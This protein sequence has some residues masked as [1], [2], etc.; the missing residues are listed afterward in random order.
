MGFGSFSASDW[1]SY[2]GTIK[3]KAVDKIYTSTSTPKEFLPSEITVREAFDTTDNPETTPIILALDVTGSMGSVLESCAK[4]IG[5]L[6]LS[7]IDRKTVL[8]PQIA[9][10]AIGDVI[11]DSEPALQFTQFESDNR[12]AHQLTQLHFTRGGGGNDNESYS[13]AWLAGAYL[14]DCHAL[15]KRNKKGYLFTFGD[16]LP[17]QHLT[18]EHIRKIFPNAD[19]VPCSE[20]GIDSETA[21]RAAETKWHCFHIIIA[22]GSYAR[23]R[24][25]EV[26]E[27]WTNLMGQRAIV[28]DNVN[29]I[30]EVI[31]SIIEVNE[32]RDAKEVIESWD[33]SKAL[34]VKTAI[35]SLTSASK[36]EAGLVPL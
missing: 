24:P 34:S 30:S 23:A 2:S 31:T 18:F 27:H 8:G 5:E 32:G 16:E 13:L 7:I 33:G 11:C 9:S 4:N 36:S 19:L 29:N 12:C 22:Q 20:T 26:L 14:T 15:T 17:T 3:D 21:L 6:M 28:L 35:S 25:K 1:K 10:M